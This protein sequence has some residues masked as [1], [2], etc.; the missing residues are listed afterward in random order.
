[1]TLKN[2][3]IKNI[4]KEYGV[5]LVI[6]NKNFN[7]K[8][9]MYDGATYSP[10]HKIITLGVFENSDH[11]IYSFFHELGHF[12]DKDI[13]R[14]FKKNPWSWPQPKTFYR[15][16]VNAWNNADFLMV[17]H[18]LELSSEYKNLREEYLEEYKESIKK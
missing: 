12:L 16:E 17:K 18:G 11:K 2:I 1:M 6:Q 13:N 4:A 3:K 5:K 8:D 9:I 14:Y 7:E 10:T 15:F